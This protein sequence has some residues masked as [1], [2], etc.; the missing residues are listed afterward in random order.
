MRYFLFIF[1]LTHQLYAQER[2][3]CFGGDAKFVPADGKKLLIIGQD[4]GAVGGLSNYNQGYIDALGYYPAG[5]TSYT[6]IVNLQGLASKTNYGAGDVN[7]QEYVDNDNFTNSTIAIGLHL[8]GQEQSIIDGNRDYNI[9]RL[10]SW[11]KES[12]RPVFLR[13]GYEFD[14]PHNNYNPSNYIKMYQHIVDVF[15]EERVLNCDFVWQSDGVHASNILNSYYPGDKY[16]DWMAFSYFGE[17]AGNA[18]IEL[19]KRKGKPVMI[20]EATPMG[21]DLEDTTEDV[22][23]KW[24]SPLFNLIEKNNE[25]KALAY[26]NVDWN[27]QPMWK[28]SGINWGDSR[29]QVNQKV[30]NNWKSETNDGTWLKSSSELFTSLGYPF[31]AEENC[32]ATVTSLEQDLASQITVY[33]NLSN[34]KIELKDNISIHQLT[35]IELGSGKVIEEVK[36]DKKSTTLE[37]PLRS[38]LYS[39]VMYN[40]LGEQIIKKVYH[41]TK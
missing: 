30:L 36:L 5:I 7:A 39:L 25:I 41:T 22:W 19:A 28:N 26:I 21:F 23:S 34:L 40:D 1:L 11:I 24:F 33:S 20:A 37:L 4:L 9:R 15:D 38:G 35:I 18:I 10:A 6:N 3:A 2:S 8:V 27:A 31:L 17:G 12:K 29:I 16:V 14:G 32:F 13:I